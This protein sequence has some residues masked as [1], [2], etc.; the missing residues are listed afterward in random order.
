LENS[1]CSGV[2]AMLRV[3]KN[4]QKVLHKLFGLHDSFSYLCIVN[5]KE[6]LSLKARRLVACREKPFR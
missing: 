5:E 6:G 1:K 3:A 4:N 2:A